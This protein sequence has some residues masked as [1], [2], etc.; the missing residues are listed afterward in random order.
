MRPSSMTITTSATSRA[1]SIS[2]VTT[3]MVM[4]SVASS[5]ITCSTSPTSSGSSADVGSS[6]SITRGFIA[7]DA[8]DGDALLLAAGQAGRHGMSI[9]GAR[10]DLVQQGP[11]LRPRPRH[12]VS[13]RSLRGPSVTLSS[14]DRCGN[15]LNDWNTMPTSWRRALQSASASMRP[16]LHQRVAADLDAAALGVLQAVAAAQEGALA[17]TAGA[18][19]D[20]HLRG[21][22]VEVDAVQHQRGRRR[23]CAS[24]RMLMMGGVSAAMLFIAPCL[25]PSAA[26]RAGPAPAT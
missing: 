8:G 18:D 16:S 9:F 3:I 6:N 11:R 15:R 20:H 22:H 7:S 14:T 5:F 10:P 21:Q 19:D 1:N 13:P 4:P 17:R 12:G 23:T 24:P 26:I 2:W 25:R